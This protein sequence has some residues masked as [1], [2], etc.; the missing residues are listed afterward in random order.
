M[1]YE[2]VLRCG[3]LVSAVGN[4]GNKIFNQA[5]L[6]PRVKRINLNYLII[7]QAP[8]FLTEKSFGLQIAFITTDRKERKNE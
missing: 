4:F 8:S 1:N 5:Q 7:V 3:K 6:R 2:A